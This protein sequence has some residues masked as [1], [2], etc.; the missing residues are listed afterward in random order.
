MK[1][2]AALTAVLLAGC[3][4]NTGYVQGWPLIPT[5]NIAVHR[6]PYGD[7][8]KACEINP[9]AF[10][11]SFPMG[12]ARVNLYKNRCDVYVPEDPPLWIVQH[13]LEH[14]NGGD[15]FGVLQA[16]YDAWVKWKADLAAWEKQYGKTLAQWEKEVGMTIHEY[17]GLDPAKVR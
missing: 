10:L 9:L 8:L 14:C 5:E 1:R 6:V 15:H 13:E 4:F 11:I 7:M 2:I 16:H 17:Y 3:S 12:C